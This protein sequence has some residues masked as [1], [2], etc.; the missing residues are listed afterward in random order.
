MT[1]SGE[2]GPNA[3]ERVVTV[4]GV[5]GTESSVAP[6]GKNRS[7]TTDSTF[8][9]DPEFESR[10]LLHIREGRRY[11]FWRAA[12]VGLIAGLM[13]VAFQIALRAA[14]FLRESVSGHFRVGGGWGGVATMLFCGLL[15]AAANFA[16][17]RIAPEAS[18]S[19]IPHVKGVLIGLRQFR[20][21]RVV[22]AKFVGGFLALASGMSLGREGPTIHIGAACG[23]G[24]AEK[25]KTKKRSYHTLISAGAGAGLAAA[26]NAP[27]AGF[28]FV[29]EELRRELTPITYGAALIA[30]V[31]ADAVTRMLVGQHSA[32]HITGY[33]APPMSALPLVAALGVLAGLLGVIFNKCL[34]RTGDLVGGL[35]LRSEVKGLVAGALA[36]LAVWFLP[37]VTGGGH[38][39]AEIVL[40][41][42]YEHSRVFLVLMGLLVA[43]FV[44]TVLSYASGAPGGIFA[45]MLVIGALLGLGFGEIA[46]DYLLPMQVTPAAFAVLGMAALFSSVVRSPL[47]GVM[48]I[49]EMTANYEQVYALIVACLFSYLVAEALK[50]E[51][52]YDAL[53]E[54]EISRPDPAAK[55]GMEPMVREIYVEPG[56]LLDGM[57]VGDMSLPPECI[58]VS[59]LRGANEIVAAKHFHIRS[60]DLVVLL[61][62]VE[63]AHL[64]H[65]VGE[66]AKTPD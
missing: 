53:L 27:L 41:G 28:L 55:P 39:I 63:N 9:H 50:D 59:V 7:A 60:G 13:A 46:R 56:S 47:T 15:G 58:L 8:H 34:V 2:P 1:T 21:V 22:V 19:G 33:H 66:W 48:L 18:G 6:A 62:E 14:E 42:Q 25:L 23:M 35:P 51:P 30:S 38:R 44:L 32:F 65:K 10:R 43:K 11:Q 61:V 12:L 5:Q 16:T 54:R 17:A 4:P 3:E 31:T 57:Q 52:V 45:P 26:F 49:V 37:E 29:I 20:W 24:V 36:G 40:S 64:L